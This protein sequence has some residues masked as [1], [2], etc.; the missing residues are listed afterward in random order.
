MTTFINR[1]H[2]ASHVEGWLALVMASFEHAAVRLVVTVV[3][4][5]LHG[6]HFGVGNHIEPPPIGKRFNS[7]LHDGYLMIFAFQP[8]I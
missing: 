7:G 2:D 4:Q 1:Y 8:G 3:S 6:D 5:E